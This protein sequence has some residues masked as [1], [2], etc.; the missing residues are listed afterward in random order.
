MGGGQSQQYIMTYD[1]AE[2]VIQHDIK[3]LKAL[4]DKIAN[5]NQTIR[6]ADFHALIFE[7]MLR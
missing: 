7:G 3:R 1:E 4:F 5:G 6:C 2:S